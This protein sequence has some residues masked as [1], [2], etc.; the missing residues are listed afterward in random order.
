MI[1]LSIAPGV[2]DALRSGAPVV[3][4]ESTIVAHGMPY[5]QSL[6]TAQQVE[7]LIWDN[8]AVPATIAVVRGDMKI[9]LSSAELAEL[10]RSGPSMAK[11][12]TR[13]LAFVASRRLSGATTV[14]A[15]ARLAALA[16]IPVFA[17]GGIGG[18]HRGAAQSFDVSADLNEIARSDIVVVTAGAKAILDLGA[19][20]EM[21][22]TLGVPVVGFGTSD[23]PAF[24]S[25]TSGLAVP[26]RCD[27]AF[28]IAT[29]FRH[30]RR[31][32]LPGGIVVANP[33]PKEHEIPEADIGPAIEKAVFEA[34]AQ[35]IAGRE[36]TPF[37]LRR[38][39]EATSGRSLAAN[40]ELVKHNA[41]R[42]AEIAGCLA[43]FSK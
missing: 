12:S 11:V 19:T 20:L 36:V 23:F 15:T 1:S 41:Q 17:T 43:E 40:I 31:L 22:E 4:L 3:A 14:A 38:L 9:G 2:E 30:K 24:Y 25:R 37:L 32:G 35:G 6:E 27:T 34:K 8:G 42:A 18:V 10:A 29:L 21:L 33:I 13:D 16:G 39:A 5:P 26:M 7:A 28:E